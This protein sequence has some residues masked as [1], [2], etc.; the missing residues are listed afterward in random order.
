MASFSSEEDMEKI[1]A[2]TTELKV[3]EIMLATT[4]PS[5]DIASVTT[6]TIPTTPAKE[7]HMKEPASVTTTTVST[8]P[9]KKEHTKEPAVGA[10]PV[11]L[12]VPDEE[13]KP[14]SQQASSSSSPTK[15]KPH[16][17]VGDEVPATPN[18]KRSMREGQLGH[19][20]PI[21]EEALQHFQ[22]QAK[23]R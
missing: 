7:E 11:S 2:G 23:P 15:P 22:I 19:L 6:T 9:A 17:I 1:V 13:K 10:T 8:T 18:T 3:G 4:T 12:T 21:Q 5:Q 14:E 16:L 20:T